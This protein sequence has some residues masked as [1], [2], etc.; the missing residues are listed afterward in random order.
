MPK[1]VR[2]II[3]EL[4]LLLGQLSLCIMSLGEDFKA[5]NCLNSF[6]NNLE[7]KLEFFRASM[8]SFQRVCQQLKDLVGS[9]SVGTGQPEER[10]GKAN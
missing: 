8:T 7:H 4:R 6:S 9:C 5:L 3:V 10:D 1:E 2:D